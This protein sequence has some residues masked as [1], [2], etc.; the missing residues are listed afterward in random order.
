MKIL[1]IEPPKPPSSIGGDDV[2][3][4]EPLALE[5]LAAGVSY[6]HEVRILDL[7]LDNGLQRALADFHPDIVGITAYTVHV[8]VVRVLFEQ[9]KAWDKNVL[10]VVGGHHAT[11]LPE[12]FLSPFIDLIVI[13]EGV[14]VFKEIVTRLNKGKPFDG[15]PGIAFAKGDGLVK[16]DSRAALD[17][18]AFPFPN[19]RPT[20]KYRKH[21]YS[22]WMKPLASIRTSKGCPYRC[23]FC[24]P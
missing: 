23:K 11:I 9:I 15:I 19:R 16:T 20:A 2:F 12:D 13:G 5:Y 18:D 24:A 8:N 10:T 3:L 14:F 21:Y 7:R 22:E 4:F 17:L 6:E 1:L